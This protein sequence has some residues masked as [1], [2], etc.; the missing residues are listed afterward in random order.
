[1]KKIAMITHIL[2]VLIFVGCSSHLTK[3]QKLTLKGDTNFELNN[4][5]LTN[6]GRIQLDNLIDFL[7]ISIISNITIIGHT[8]SQ[9]TDE[10]NQ[11]LSEKRAESVKIYM[12]LKGIPNNLLS[13]IGM[14]ENDPIADNSTLLGRALNRRVS[15]EITTFEKKTFY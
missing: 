4:A 7:D 6:A 11:K 3:I 10:Y 9:G 8:D 14:G 5:N 1:M 2:F 15:I 12:L 13:T